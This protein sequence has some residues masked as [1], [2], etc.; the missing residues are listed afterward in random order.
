MINMGKGKGGG[1]GGGNQGGNVVE[2]NPKVEMKIK[3]L[4]EVRGEP[5]K[6]EK[7]VAIKNSSGT[8]VSFNPFPGEHPR[9]TAFRKR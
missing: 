6:E 5:T 2:A 3:V 7:R 8:L 1:G 9:S 4:L